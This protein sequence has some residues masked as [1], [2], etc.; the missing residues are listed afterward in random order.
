MQSRFIVGGVAAILVFDLVASL[1]SRSLGFPYTRAA[2]GSY[3]IYFMIGL[4]VARA[5]GASS[6]RAAAT[7]AAIAGFAEASLGWAISWQV[8]PGRLPPERAL[9]VGSWVGI[10]IFVVASAAAIGALGG[11]VGRRTQPLDVP[12]P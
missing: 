3:L 10:A 11:V 5:G 12:V 1:A 6:V 8:G 9:T 7:A 4:L 2:W